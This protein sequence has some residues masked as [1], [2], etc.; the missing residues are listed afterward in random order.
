MS[1]GE[2]NLDDF[3][4][5]VLDPITFGKVYWPR[6]VIYEKQAE[7][8]QSLTINDETMVV[9]GNQLG[10]DFIT[11]FICLWYFLSRT[12]CRIVTSSASND[13]L[14]RVL[15]G[16]MKQFID[17]ARFTLP[18]Q[19]NHKLIRKVNQETGGLDAKSYLVGLVPDKVE[20]MQGHHLDRD[21]THRTL[22]VFD[23]AS[24]LEDKY[25]RATD[26]WAHRKLV[27]GNPLPCVNFFYHGVKNGDAESATPGR[28]YRKVIRIRAEDSPNVQLGLAQKA[29]GRPITNE[30][31]VPG[32][33]DYESYVK[34]RL[35]WD[36]IQQCVGLDGLFYEGAELRLY[37]PEWL[38]RA[39]SL[40]SSAGLTR[41][42]GLRTMG[43]DP[44]E[45]GDNTAWTIVDRYGI[46]YQLSMKTADTSMVGGRTL[47]LM[48]EFK[49]NAED[50]LFDAGGGGKEHAD[51]LRARGHNVRTVR[52]SE[53]AT[54]YADGQKQ[55]AYR[56]NKAR[57]DE[58]EEKY[59]YKNRRMEMYGMLRGLLRPPIDG[60]VL[61]E[62][63]AGLPDDVA[64]TIA[65]LNGVRLAE[66]GSSAG[67]AIPAEYTELIRQLS[68]L[69]LLYDAEGRMYL[70]PKNKTSKDST[71]LTITDIIGHSPDEADS[72]VLAVFGL[73]NRGP[74]RMMGVPF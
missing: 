39:M 23:E 32:V 3:K 74:K 71:V 54:K 10:K 17:S 68:L 34:R 48:R 56:S 4:Q 30:W 47:A 64:K 73:F 20:T 33:L 37:P 29:A 67:F 7:I 62:A 43:V 27:I 45:G 42:T 6:M 31:L 51:Y 5:L 2:L 63:T 66:T 41:Q 22:A 18:I 60:E 57:R 15:W 58:A 35:M 49:V 40:A 9:A 36:A 21:G 72:L 70:P 1:V 65:H 55:T 50:V 52:F 11:G 59:V 13:Q 25:Y 28:L 8:L 24:G 44:A 14:E 26:T 69:P 46:I 38:A 16:E 12:P 19:Y 53:G 61:A